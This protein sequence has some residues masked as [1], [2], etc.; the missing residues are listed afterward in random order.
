MVPTTLAQFDTTKAMRNTARRY[1]V[2]DVG[3]N[4]IRLVIF[5]RLS[6]GLSVM[7]NEKILCGLGSDLA[8]TSRLTQKGIDQA[9]DNLT[10]FNELIKAME[11]EVLDAVATAAV[12]DAKDGALF[13]KRVAQECDLQLR[14][15]SGDEECRYTALGVLA[16]VPEADGMVGDL[17][18][19]SL[20]LV[21][22][23]G[24]DV[25]D[26]LTLPLGP[27]RLVSR[28]AEKQSDVSYDIERILTKARIFENDSAGTFYL[29]GGNWRS[30]ARLHMSQV[31]YPLRVVHRYTMGYEDIHSFTELVAKQSP[32]SLI[33][34]NGIAEKR[35][36][37]LPVAA[38][39]LLALLQRLRPSEVVFCGTGLREGLAYARLDAH[40]RAK[41]PLISVCTD[42]ARRISRFPSHGAELASWIGLMFPDE[43]GREKRLRCAACLLSDIA[44]RV[45]PDYRAEYAL[46]EALWLQGPLDHADRA[47]LG[48]ATMYRYS[49]RKAP[50]L[51]AQ[52]K[53]LLDPKSVDQ[54]RTV[55]LAARVGETLCGGVP[56]LLSRFTL[57]RE[58]GRLVLRHAAGDF[59]MIGHVVRSRFRALA[60]HLSLKDS[61]EV[62]DS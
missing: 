18:G 40:E 13:V 9:L 17:G 49:S 34:I 43:T 28:N 29:V 55:G 11:V 5:D 8:L 56:G 10:R 7:F 15:L 46:M 37:L 19:G 6:R 57:A 2:I 59:R 4:S 45:H 12:R 14:V 16:S 62:N 31:N 39:V 26:T 58:D 24:D 47:F 50:K 60:K 38:K 25:S 36:D 35:L 27:L 20:E 1:A 54:A 22:I 48:L 41:D 42:L 3:S 52:V 32:T 23:S 53:H 51:A 21:R 44:W 61:V 30:L 33:G